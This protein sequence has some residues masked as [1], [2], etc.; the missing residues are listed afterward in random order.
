[1]IY[2]FLLLINTVGDSAVSNVSNAYQAVSSAAKELSLWEL[3][4]KGGPVMLAIGLLSVA[5]VYLFVMKLL[6]VMKASKSETN[7]M[8][9]IKFCSK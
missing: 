5:L 7:F 6:V 4:V 8:N 3:I 2:S 1:M 9:S